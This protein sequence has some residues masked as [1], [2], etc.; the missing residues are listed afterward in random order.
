[1]GFRDRLDPKEPLR[2][3]ANLEHRRWCGHDGPP[4]H[5]A[6]SGCGRGTWTEAGQT[7]AL[8]SSDRRGSRRRKA[9]RVT[10][11]RLLSRHGLRGYSHHSQQSFLRLGKSA[12]TSPAVDLVLTVEK[13]FIHAALHFEVPA[14]GLLRGRF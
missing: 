11:I 9:D 1:M 2:G 8:H 6:L 14:C 10:D 4:G 12:V 13:L 3:A 7:K 5:Y